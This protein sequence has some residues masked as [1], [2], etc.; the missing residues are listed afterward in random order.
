MC[1]ECRFCGNTIRDFNHLCE[2]RGVNFW[3][4]SNRKAK[5]KRDKLKKS[6]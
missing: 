6:R 2:K 4:K 3:I 1:Y 5:N